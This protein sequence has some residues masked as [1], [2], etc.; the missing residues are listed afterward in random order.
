MIQL[1]PRDDPRPL[2]ERFGRE[3]ALGAP[4]NGLTWLGGSAPRLAVAAGDGAVRVFDPALALQ[5]KYEAHDGAI[6]GFAAARDGGSVISGGDDGRVLR[7]DGHGGSEVITRTR[8]RW[9]DHVATGPDGLLAWSEGRRAVVL[10]A[11]GRRELDHQSTVGGLAFDDAGGRLAVAHYNGASIWTLDGT[12]APAQKPRMLGW[13][14]SHVGCLFAPGGR[15]LVTIMQ[16]NALHGWRLTDAGN[17]RMSGYPSKPRSLSFSS[18]GL[19][20]ATSGAEGVVLWPFKGK[21]GPM[22][23][24]GEIASPRPSIVTAVAFH[25]LSEV[26]LVGYSDGCVMM[27]RRGDTPLVVVRRPRPGAI[28]AVGWSATGRYVAYASDA[29]VVGAIDLAQAAA[30][31]GA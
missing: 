23:K 24:S 8:G 19:W 10:D 9:I 29:G 27:A 6:L 30:L 7:L 21:D 3:I 13:K 16:E 12:A 26:M 11:K 14:G 4:L 2:V 5:H 1:T 22:G 17:M 25:P 28:A 31:P 20:L 15:F 18:N